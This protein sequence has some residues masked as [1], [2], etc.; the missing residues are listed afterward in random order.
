MLP[1]LLALQL[2][3]P[4]PTGFVN[5]F[6]GVL[7]AESRREMLAVIDQVKQKSG[8][9]IVV[10]TL[11]D[12]DGRPSIDV[13]R[14]IGRQWKVG[15]MGGPGDRARNAGVLVLFK[16]GA[17]PGDGQADIAIATGTGSEGFITDAQAGRIRD[18]IGR[19]S[20]E[21][22]SYARGLAAGV[23]MLGQAYANEFAFQFTGEAQ[24]LSQQAAPST[25]VPWVF[26]IV[27][28]ILF[29]VFASRVMR[30]RSRGLSSALFWAILSSRGRHGGWSGASRGGGWGRSGGGFGGF[31]GGGGFSGGGASGRF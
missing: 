6:A 3:V 17:R 10:V 7:D 26:V 13:A 14:D 27:P 2:Q 1:L 4:A 23:A 5:D 9:E 15:A 30:Y 16:P 8:G 18:A 24:A 19:Q 28:V 12:L 25:G 21:S 11:R 22:G 29:F 20:V 31:G